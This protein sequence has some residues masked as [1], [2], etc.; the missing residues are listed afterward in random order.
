MAQG[1]KPRGGLE[2]QGGAGD[3]PRG[4]LEEPGG[5]GNTSPVAGWKNR[6]AQGT[7]PVAGWGGA[8]HLPLR[9][10]AETAIKF[11]EAAAVF[12]AVVGQGEGFVLLAGL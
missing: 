10:R 9:F 2:E 11:G 7:S 8:I 5:A 12:D 4:G 1:T 3:K 6:V